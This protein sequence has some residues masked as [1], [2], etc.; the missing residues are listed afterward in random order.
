[1]EMFG[2]VLGLSVAAWVVIAI[3]VALVFPVLWLWMLIDAILRDIED[4]PSRDQIEKI[5]WIVLILTVQPV[6]ALYFFLV[7]ARQRRGQRA[8]IPTAGP[9]APAA[10]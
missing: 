10:V 4:Y 9:A 8:D 1:M 7:W 5:L 3:M 2:A 6:A